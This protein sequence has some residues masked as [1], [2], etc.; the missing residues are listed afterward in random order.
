MAWLRS[1]CSGAAF[2]QL[3]VPLLTE[4][5]YQSIA[6][7]VVER[8]PFPFSA[9]SA[10]PAFRDLFVA[11]ECFSGAADAHGKK[12]ARKRLA[13]GAPAFKKCPFEPAPGN[14]PVDI[15][16]HACAAVDAGC[17]IAARK[18]LYEAFPV[19]HRNIPG[20]KILFDQR[21]MLRYSRHLPVFQ[22]CAPPAFQR[23]TGSCAGAE[24]AAKRGRDN[25]I[26]H[27]GIFDAKHTQKVYQISGTKKRGRLRV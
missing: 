8:H 27:Q 7:K 25:G 14:V 15:H 24:V 5:P 10:G 20:V 9:F 1:P 19:Y 22:R 21:I 16:E 26:V 4:F 2:E 17:R 13:P 18:P 23:A 6:Q 12:M 11:D 3:S